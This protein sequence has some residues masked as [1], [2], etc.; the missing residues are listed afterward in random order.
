MTHNGQSQSQT[1]GAV[2]LPVGNLHV[3]V[4]DA[5]LV[6]RCNADAGIPDFKPQTIATM[7]LAQAQQDSP[8][9][10]VTHGIGQQVAHDALKQQAVGLQHHAVT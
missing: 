7:R 9:A 6:C 4:K 3:G 5:C 1:L 8:L 10:G 2:A